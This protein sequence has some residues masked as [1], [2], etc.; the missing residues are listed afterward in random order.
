[1]NGIS[2]NTSSLTR[3]LSVI[4]DFDN[5]GREI[6]AQDERNRQRDGTFTRYRPLGRKS[7]PNLSGIHAEC[8]FGQDEDG[9]ALAG[10][11][12]KSVENSGVRI[13][14]GDELSLHHK[15]SNYVASNPLKTLLGLAIP[16]V[17]LIFYGR[18]GKEHLQLSMKLLHTRVFGQFATLSRKCQTMCR[19]CHH[20]FIRKTCRSCCTLP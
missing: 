10:L 17:G 7:A 8:Q 14:P 13:V 16:S 1:M 18:T 12:R 2:H 20:S 5:T 4:R 19:Q 9:S 3:S 15:V 6:D 11:Y